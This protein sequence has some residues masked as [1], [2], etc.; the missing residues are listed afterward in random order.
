M[1]ALS[2]TACG[3][4]DDEPANPNKPDQPTT[5]EKDPEGT[6]LANM[7]C[8][9]N[10]D[11]ATIISIEPD[12]QDGFNTY[13]V[14]LYLLYDMNWNF[15]YYGSTP[16]I[17]DCGQVKN[18]A[19]I[20]VIPESGWGKPAVQPGHGYIMR[21]LQD[22]YQDNIYIY[23]YVYTRIYVTQYLTS[24]TGEIIGATIKYQPGWQVSDTWKN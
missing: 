18:I 12:T 9:T 1:T 17:V 22:K 7:M 11:N 24:T 2:F 5:T 16:A 6:I 8:G 13:E 21:Q 14:G 3:G 10:R 20:N 15:S 19:A 4:D 23:R